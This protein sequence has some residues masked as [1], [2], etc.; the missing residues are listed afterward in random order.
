MCRR[1]RA[2]DLLN[3]IAPNLTKTTLTER[4]KGIL[5]EGKLKRNFIWATNKTKKY[6][7]HQM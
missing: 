5:F 3:Q 6:L 2:T 4:E 1:V 7:P